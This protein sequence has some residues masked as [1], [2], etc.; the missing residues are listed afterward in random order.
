M[1]LQAQGKDADFVR[2]V[3][4]DYTKAELSAVDRALCDYAAKLTRRPWEMSE[5]D[6]QRLRGVGLSDAAILDAV[7][8]IAYFNYINR[9]ADGL[10]VDLEDFMKVP[11]SRPSTGAS[12]GK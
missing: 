7:Q 3:K 10:G 11:S 9:V 5:A 12:S 8:V 2:H 1:D 4:H 6:V